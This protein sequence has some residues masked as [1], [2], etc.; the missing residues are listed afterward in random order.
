MFVLMLAH[1][2]NKR[3]DTGPEVGQPE[4]HLTHYGLRQFH[5]S[6]RLW[7]GGISWCLSH[8]WV[9]YPIRPKQISDYIY[10]FH[11]L[12]MI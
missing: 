5:L 1:C 2:P 10:E 8:W 4:V 6:I 3:S 11:K 9:I 12:Q 7:F